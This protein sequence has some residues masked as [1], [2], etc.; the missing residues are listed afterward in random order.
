[1]ELCSI[2]SGSSGNCVYIGND[3]THLLLDAGISGKKIEQ[4][5]SMID[6]NPEHLS[7]ILITHEH[8]DHV[9]G[10]GVMVRR[11]HLPVYATAETIHAAMHGKSSIGKI[12]GECIHLV[13]PDEPF[14]IQD[15]TVM[16]FSISHDAANPV[17]YTFS[18]AD[19]KK[20]GIATDLGV[21]DDYIVRHLSGSDA[22]LLEANHDISMLEVG[23]YPYVLKQRILGKR[24]HLSNDNTGKLLN[25]LMHPELKHVFLGHLSKENNYPELAFETVKYEMEKENPDILQSIS[26]EVAKRDD[27]CEP[28]FV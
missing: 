4:G 14:A 21:Y 6:I 2:A 24:G 17:S 7:G 8:S 19:G 27:V 10:L 12:P 11:Y 15:I 22:L 16:P 1:M 5:L 25:E 26:L 9:K 23:P 18:Q 13:T 20:I 3:N 28:V